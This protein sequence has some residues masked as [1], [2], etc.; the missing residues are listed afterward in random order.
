MSRTTAGLFAGYTVLSV[1][2]LLLL[3]AHAASAI[4]GLRSGT[5][6]A[7]ALVLTGVGT[8]AYVLGFGL[9]VLILGRLPLAR[10]YPLAV[11]LTLALTTLAAKLWLGEPI[12]L[13]IAAGGF[14]VLAGIVLL[15]IP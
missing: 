2:G 1:I 5:V 4:A 14:A 6:D 10:A 12:T 9:W 13:R 11:G 8:V 3:R 15:T 7:T